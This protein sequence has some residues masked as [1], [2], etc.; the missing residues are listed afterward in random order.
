MPHTA[1]ATLLVIDDNPAVAT[2]LE[3]LFSLHDLRTLHAATPEQGLEL[4]RR[5]P[6]DL[7]I[8][9]MNFSADTTSGE[10]GE[11]LFKAIRAEHPG[12]PVI[13]LTAWTHLESAVD[14]VR[15][16]AADYL[17]KP[18][19]DNKLLA[20]VS[21]LLELGQASRALAAAA[22]VERQRRHRLERNYNL[23]G[24]V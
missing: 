19:D 24:L 8:Q 12:L 2:A 5:E 3:V 22:G 7:V 15:A 6:V 4:L 16:G 11:A 23:C 14:L 18:W 1:H 13:L 21:N 9:D 10:E 17:A 20:T